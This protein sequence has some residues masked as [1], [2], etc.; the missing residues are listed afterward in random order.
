M[1]FLPPTFKG[2]SYVDEDALRANL[3]DI[4]DDLLEFLRQFYLVFA[5]FGQNDLFLF[6]ESFAGGY[7]RQE[8][9][10]GGKRAN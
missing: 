8:A 5:E 10:R 7:L 1:P 2:F 4:G 3:S 9:E 6:G